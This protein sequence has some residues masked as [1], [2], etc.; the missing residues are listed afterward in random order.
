MDA[1]SAE[2]RVGYQMPRG[3]SQ[4][5][6][7]LWM[8]GIEFGSPGRVVEA[9]LQPREPSLTKL[10]SVLGDVGVT[11]LGLCGQITLVL[12]LTFFNWNNT[13]QHAL[14]AE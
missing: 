7:A 4:L 3:Y 5:L 2:D 8:P 9:S 12:S 13:A 10:F 11:H 6:A 14:G 1:T